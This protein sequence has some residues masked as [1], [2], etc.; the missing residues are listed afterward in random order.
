MTNAIHFNILSAEWKKNDTEARTVYSNH[1]NVLG[2][3]QDVS[4]VWI[5]V[6]KMQEMLKILKDQHQLFSGVEKRKWRGTLKFAAV[7]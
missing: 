6:E 7:Q 5:L 1:I 4:A 3:I 2:R